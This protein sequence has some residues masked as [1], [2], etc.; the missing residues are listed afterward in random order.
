MHISAAATGKLNRIYNG[1]RRTL[2][3]S[4]LDI[5]MDCPQRERGGWLCDSH[6]AAQAAW[7]SSEISAQRKI[8]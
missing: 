6:F 5:F 1:A 2:R 8:L 4:T 7:Q 3:L